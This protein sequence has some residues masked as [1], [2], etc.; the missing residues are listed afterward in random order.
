MA[1]K[2]FSNSNWKS[3]YEESY[4]NIDVSIKAPVNSPQYK[5]PKD[6]SGKT[7]VEHYVNLVLTDTH[8]NNKRT[9]VGIFVKAQ[10]WAAIR[11][12]L[13]IIDTIPAAKPYLHK[14]FGENNEF[15]IIRVPIQQQSSN[16]TATTIAFAKRQWNKADSAEEEDTATVDTAALAVKGLT[17]ADFD[18]G[19]AT[20]YSSPIHYNVTAITLDSA[21]IGNLLKDTALEKLALENASAGDV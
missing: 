18:G 7:V 11:Q 5:K 10:Q 9:L 15:I 6:E 13:H 3:F 1:G 17:A 20:K 2:R 19:S 14:Q 16:S 4:S 8:N 12:C 21:M